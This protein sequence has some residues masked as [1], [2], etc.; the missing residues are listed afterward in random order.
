MKNISFQK[1]IYSEDQIKILYQLLEKRLFSISHQS[2]PTYE[3]H[4]S[5]VQKNPYIDWFLIFLNNQPI[6]SFYIQ[7]DNSVGIN[8]INQNKKIIKET[9]NFVA[10]H[11]S[12]KSPIPSKVPPYFFVNVPF[13]NDTMIKALEEIEA[14]PIQLSYRIS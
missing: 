9:I 12:P 13:H 4:S 2:M 8:L 6:G 14:K 11:F 1:I 3:D 7:E 5:F 10:S